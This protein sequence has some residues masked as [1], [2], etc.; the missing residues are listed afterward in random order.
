MFCFKVLYTNHRNS[1]NMFVFN[2]FVYWHETFADACYGD[3]GKIGTL[4]N[5]SSM[6]FFCIKIIDTHQKHIFYSFVAPWQETF[7]DAGM[8]IKWSAA[9]IGWASGGRSL[10]FLPLYGLRFQ[11]NKIDLDELRLGGGTRTECSTANAHKNK[12][13]IMFCIPVVTEKIFSKNVAKT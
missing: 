7:A 10:C 4:S 6:F 11:T 5:D 1:S 8:G 3:G 13:V 2:F 12:K 9:Q